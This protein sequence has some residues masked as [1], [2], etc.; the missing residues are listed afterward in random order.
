MLNDL[1]RIAPAPP[2]RPAPGAAP[3][4]GAPSAEPA[5]ALLGQRAAVRRDLT[6]A[7][8]ALG[9]PPDEG[10]LLAAQALV[11]FGIPLTA[12]DL[13]DVRRGLASRAARQPETVALAKSLGL[14]PS[15]AILRAL[16]TLLSARTDT[17]LLTITVPMRLAGDVRPAGDVRLAGDVRPDTAAIAAHLQM[18]TRAATL[19][20]EARLLTGDIDGARSDLRSHLLRRAR[21]GDTDA[22]TAARHL[23]GQ[24]PANV[25]RAN[26]PGETDGPI[27]VAFTAATNGRAH[28][29]EMQVE[30]S[31]DE[32]GDAGAEASDGAAVGATVRIRRRTWAW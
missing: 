17:S 11:R 9:V 29:V 3:G 24:M 27:F 23:E 31:A 16:D 2:V 28:P 4:A 19:S 25:A 12:E 15:P 1:S 26:E 10:R 21:D 14:P 20:G 5:A 32:Q 6:A 8:A 18:T 22:E 7:L 13:A 30:R